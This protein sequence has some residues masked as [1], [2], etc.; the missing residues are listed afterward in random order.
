[1]QLALLLARPAVKAGAKH[2]G[3]TRVFCQIH[4]FATMAISR[5]QMEVSALRAEE[6]VGNAQE[7]RK[8]SVLPATL[9][10]LSILQE[11]VCATRAFTWLLTL[12]NVRFATQVVAPAL[13]LEFRI[14]TRVSHLLFYQVHV[15]AF[16]LSGTIQVAAE[17]AQNAAPNAGPV[18][19]DRPVRRVLQEPYSPN[20]LANAV[21]ELHQ[22]LTVP[23]IAMSH[24]KRASTPAPINAKAAIHR[25]MLLALPF[26]LRVLAKADT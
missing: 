7:L 19:T 14:V 4:A 24:A 12:L 20:L 18:K 8:P 23:R 3:Q 13:V 10:R 22:I 5:I 11:N 15:P 6:P 1:M 21:P 16:A 25:R 17:H 9:G 26:L 2:V